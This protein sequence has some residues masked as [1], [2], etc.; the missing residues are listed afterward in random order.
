MLGKLQPPPAAGD[1]QLHDGPLSAVRDALAGNFDREHGGFG[2]APK[3]PH[4]TTL[5]RLLRHW[6]DTANEPEPDVEALYMAALTLARMAEGGMYDQLGGGFHRYSTD[7]KW[8]VPHF[9]KMLYDNALLVPAYLERHPPER[10]DPIPA[11]VREVT[12]TTLHVQV[13]QFATRE[14]EHLVLQKE[15]WVVVLN[16]RK[17]QPFGVVR[18]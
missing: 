16:G 7:E 1:V 9:E 11:R 14:V 5:E 18:R 4:P 13:G 3:F 6:R 8:L 15:D 10:G 17:Q 12:K 2:G